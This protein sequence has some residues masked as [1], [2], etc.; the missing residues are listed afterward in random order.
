MNSPD[1]EPDGFAGLSREAF[2]HS[3]SPFR[4][5]SP[6]FDRKEWF[7]LE[8]RNLRTALALWG[9]TFLACTYSGLLWYHEFILQSE[10]QARAAEI[11]QSPWAILHGLPFA[12]GIL[13]ILGSHEMGHFLACRHYGMWCTPP[14][15]LPFPLPWLPSFG[16]AGAFIK[17]KQPFLDRRRLFDVGIAGPLAGFV[18]AIP[19]LAAGILLSRPAIPIPAPSGAEG[20]GGVLY[21]GDSLLIHLGFS[22]R[23]ESGV[24]A[25]HPLYWAAFFGF[26][27]T[28]LNL[29]PM[30]QLDGGHIVYAVFGP[31]VHRWVTWV[32]FSA[33][34]GVSVLSW[35]AAG[36][37]FF[38]GI[39]L[40][41]RIYRHPPP[42]VPGEI[43]GRLRPALA[44]AALLILVLTF[45]P[46]PFYLE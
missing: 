9:V 31:R 3:G 17:I 41:L 15:A 33:L 16:T 22:L 39:L 2:F 14:F 13:F 26:L 21:I 35:P 24:I 38:A 6:S 25:A 30:G 11:N 40:A 28:S 7:R 37:L 10:G 42:L 12:L 46:V 4:L 34:V 44:V 43:P 5:L 19:V 45:I 20:G 32:A 23:F 36:Y 18:A 1:Q 8:K 27:A 29:L